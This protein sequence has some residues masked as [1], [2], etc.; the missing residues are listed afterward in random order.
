MA[1]TERCRGRRGGGR[2]DERN[3]RLGDDDDECN[4]FGLV[5]NDGRMDG[6]FPRGMA[7]VPGNASWWNIVS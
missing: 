3:G 7:S 4:D 1:A 6:R 2:G 5:L